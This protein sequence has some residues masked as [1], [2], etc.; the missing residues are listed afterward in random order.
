M[1]HIRYIGHTVYSCQHYEWRRTKLITS[2]YR[3]QICYVLQKCNINPIW[4][5][6][7]YEQS[8]P[9]RGQIIPRLMSIKYHLKLQSIAMTLYKSH[10]QYCSGKGYVANFE[11]G[12]ASAEIIAGLLRREHLS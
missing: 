8:G 12:L 1:F 3:C 7:N 9:G 10:H 5:G 2:Y 4:S 11:I 6:L